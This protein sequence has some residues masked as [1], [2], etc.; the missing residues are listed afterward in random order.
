[1]RW[2]YIDEY[3]IYNITIRDDIRFHIHR[4]SKLGQD[5]VEEEILEH[6]SHNDKC[7]PRTFDVTKDGEYLG[8]PRIKEYMEQ[9]YVQMGID[10]KK[11]R[12]DEKIAFCNA[13]DKKMK[14]L[15]NS[16]VGEWITHLD[17]YCGTMSYSDKQ[18]YSANKDLQYKDEV[19]CDEV[20][21]VK[22]HKEFLE[23]PKEL[24]KYIEE[25]MENDYFY[26]PYTI[27][28][29]IKHPNIKKIHNITGRDELSLDMPDEEIAE[30]RKDYKWEDK[31][32]KFLDLCDGY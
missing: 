3:K 23:D 30:A 32:T 2:D 19:F 16:L 8:M 7:I 27:L 26:K 5:F 31:S 6:Y 29:S 22:I 11:Q 15:W 17:T 13:L 20:Q 14:M 21:A 4:D 12:S 10:I 25:K 9:I 28:K 18:Y 1:M 24:R